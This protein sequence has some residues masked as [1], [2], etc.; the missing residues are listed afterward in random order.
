M[1]HLRY[2]RTQVG[3]FLLNSILLNQKHSPYLD[4]KLPGEEIEEFI[5]S[6]TDIYQK[7]T[8]SN[9]YKIYT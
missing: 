8:Y 6:L 7:A 1:E 9:I 5:C 3:F 4:I 2:V